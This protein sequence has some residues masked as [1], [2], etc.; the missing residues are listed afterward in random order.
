MRQIA[1]ASILSSLVCMGVLAQTPME[2]VAD[3]VEI[4]PFFDAS[5]TTQKCAV[6][7]Q[8]VLPADPSTDYAPRFIGC[9]GER[10]PFGRYEFTFRGEMFDTTGA[11]TKQLCEVDQ[12]RTMCVLVLGIGEF[13]LPRV[14]KVKV[15]ASMGAQR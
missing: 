1:L 11:G 12:R 10:I 2:R 4:T 6:V 9:V 14:F 13:M 15:Q 7:T 5:Q 3:R 8:F